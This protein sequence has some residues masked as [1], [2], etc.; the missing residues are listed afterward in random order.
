MLTWRLGGLAYTLKDILFPA[1]FLGVPRRGSWE[2]SA[3][4]RE[5]G[6]PSVPPPQS[7]IFILYFATARRSFQA[8]RAN[9]S[10][11]RKVFISV[12]THGHQ[13]CG[14]EGQQGEAAR[15]EQRGDP[16]ECL[17]SRLCFQVYCVRDT[18]GEGVEKDERLPVQSRSGLWM[19]FFVLFKAFRLFL[20]TVNG[21]E[22]FHFLHQRK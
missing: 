16:F 1:A 5:R 11:L 7:A 8:V 15:G 6:P 2:I 17:I 9:C 12:A 21:L 3:L 22:M 19:G 18:G 4:W 14:Q 10:S 20:V 13:M